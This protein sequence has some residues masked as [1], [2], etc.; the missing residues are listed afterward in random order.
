MTTPDKPIYRH[1]L[2]EW[3]ERRGLLQEDVAKTCGTSKSVISRFERG[4]RHIKLDMQIKLMWALGVTPSQFFS[5][6]DRPSLDA[7]TETWTDDQR[8]RLADIG[9][10]LA[11]PRDDN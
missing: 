8:R 3:R 4:D 9:K 11:N 6:P 1:Y 2:R 10:V 5:H 7:L